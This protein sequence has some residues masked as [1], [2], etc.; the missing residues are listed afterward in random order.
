M[1]KACSR[2]GKL[3][4]FNSTCPYK[5][6]TRRFADT[7]ENRLRGKYSWKVKRD[8][9]KE[10][11]NYLCEVCRDRGDYTP[12]DL[13]V[14]HITKLKKDPNGLLEDKNIIALCVKHHKEADRGEL[15][16]DY[17]RALA[18]TRDARR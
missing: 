17:L 11:A 1:L 12:K 15:S 9:I 10:R 8:S 14:H 3:H 6:D 4:D 13:E 5:K 18:D 2:C 7:E 16:E